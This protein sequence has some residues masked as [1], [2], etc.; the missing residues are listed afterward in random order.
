MA[1]T[2]QVPLGAREPWNGQPCFTALHETTAPLHSRNDGVARTPIKLNERH[3]GA[4]V[5]NP[6]STRHCHCGER[7]HVSKF[8]LLRWLLKANSVH[9]G[10]LPHYN[11]V[12]RT[13][14]YIV[15]LH[16][17]QDCQ[18]YKNRLILAFFLR[19]RYKLL[20]HTVLVCQSSLILYCK[21]R[22]NKLLI[23]YL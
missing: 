6:E 15:H 9:D 11:F 4:S 2:L 19:S 20:V 5:G 16:I 10:L 3:V 13:Y 12:I 17:R 14:E 1:E 23:I 8:L 18:W 7:T 21:P 22:S